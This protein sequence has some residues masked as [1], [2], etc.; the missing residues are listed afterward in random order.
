MLNRSGYEYSYNQIR[1][2][3]DD[4]LTFYKTKHEEDKRLYIQFM[5]NDIYNCPPPP[6]TK[7]YSRWKRNKTDC[8]MNNNPSNTN[9]G[10]NVKQPKNIKVVC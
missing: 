1:D 4:L 7:T 9:K 3:E 8:L 10:A 6:V 5:N 2:E